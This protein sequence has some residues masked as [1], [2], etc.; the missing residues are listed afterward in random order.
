ML[1]QVGV[2]SPGEVVIILLREGKG[3]EWFL[4]ITLVIVKHTWLGLGDPFAP[5]AVSVPFDSARLQEEEEM[6]VPATR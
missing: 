4:M 5:H 2:K 1:E 6:A 3:N